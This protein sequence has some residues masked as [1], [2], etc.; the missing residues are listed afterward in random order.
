MLEHLSSA[1]NTTNIEQLSPSERT[2]L[3]LVMGGFNELNEKLTRMEKEVMTMQD[4]ELKNKVEIMWTWAKYLLLAGG[5]GAI[6][7]LAI[8]IK[9]LFPALNI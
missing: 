4:A 1:V 9:I 7:L 8:A 2:L 3:T 6:A 5:T